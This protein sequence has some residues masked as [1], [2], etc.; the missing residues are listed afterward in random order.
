MENES[1]VGV[2]MP[3]AFKDALFRI[4]TAWGCPQTAVVRRLIRD[5]AIRLGVWGKG[6]DA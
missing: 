5:E 6:E 4:A 2:K 1:T 3:R